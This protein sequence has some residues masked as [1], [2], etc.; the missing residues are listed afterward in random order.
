MQA[1]CLLVG[2]VFHCADPFTALRRGNQPA[3]EKQLSSA[4]PGC[5]A[6]WLYALFVIT[7]GDKR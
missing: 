4:L 7:M 1:F 2:G 3:T 6:E 5:F